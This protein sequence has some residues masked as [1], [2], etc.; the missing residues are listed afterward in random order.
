V[1]TT[2]LYGATSVEPTQHGFNLET[3]CV[4]GADDHKSIGPFH[5]CPAQIGAA[6][7]LPLDDIRHLDA[8]HSW[9]KRGDYINCFHELER[10]DFKYREEQRVLALRWRLS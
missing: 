5:F 7:S 4:A 9:L 2:E 3:G 6:M 10:I 8:A 1:P